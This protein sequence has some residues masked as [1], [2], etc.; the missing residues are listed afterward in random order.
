MSDLPPYRIEWRSNLVTGWV[1]VTPE[2]FDRTHESALDAANDAIE[3][4]GG[5]ARV[6]SQHVIAVYPA[7]HQVKSKPKDQGRST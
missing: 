1:N 2:D 5:Q 7:Q 6:I 4:W 3:K